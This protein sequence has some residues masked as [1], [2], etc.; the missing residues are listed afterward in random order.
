MSRRIFRWA[1]P[2]LL[3][4]I[5]AM[6]VLPAHAQGP[7]GF[8]IVPD[9]SVEHAGDR[10]VRA[11]TNHLI[12]AGPQFGSSSPTGKT[13]SLIYS[14]YGIPVTASPA[15]PSLNIAAGGSNV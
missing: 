9:S 2:L 6:P 7:P 13:P 15:K 1:P 10:G 12:H 11:H 4:A 8:V 5:V 14:A 3:A